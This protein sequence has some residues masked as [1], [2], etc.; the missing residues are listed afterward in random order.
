MYVLQL[1]LVNEGP[2][3]ITTMKLKIQFEA[4]L[5]ALAGARICRPTISAGCMESIHDEV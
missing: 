3:T 4:V 5:N 2:V 1:M